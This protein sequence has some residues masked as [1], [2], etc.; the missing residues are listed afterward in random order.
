MIKINKGKKR[1]IKENHKGYSKAREMGGEP[2]NQFLT[3]TAL[4]NVVADKEGREEAYRFTKSI[5]QNYAKYTI[6]GMYD[7]DNFMKCEGDIFE[8]YKKYN[9]AMF[10]ANQDYRVKEIKDEPDPGIKY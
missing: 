5:W 3:R 8:N 10:K 7:L 9:I 4:F 1:I 2:A 6:P